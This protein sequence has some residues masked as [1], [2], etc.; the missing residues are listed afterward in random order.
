M[1]ILL[2]LGVIQVMF[3]ASHVTHCFTADCWWLVL[4]WRSVFLWFSTPS[5]VD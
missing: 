1:N 3:F 2:L 4:Y 5:R